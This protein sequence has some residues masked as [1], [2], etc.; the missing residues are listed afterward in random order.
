[1]MN[2]KMKVTNTRMAILIFFARY[3]S[4]KKLH[5]LQ[6]TY[7]KNNNTYQNDNQNIHNGK[8]GRSKTYVT[9]EMVN[10]HVGC[11]FICNSNSHVFTEIY[12][13][14]YRHTVL[15]VFQVINLESVSR[16]TKRWFTNT[17][18]TRKI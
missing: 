6:E 8:F 10:T 16:I 9:T 17:K 14:I 12:K 18:R 2:M 5:F 15:V 11:C 1:M 4:R 7:D 13:F 3:K